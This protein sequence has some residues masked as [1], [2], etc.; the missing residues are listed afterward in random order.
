MRLGYAWR[1]VPQP[2]NVEI[3]RR[4]WYKPGMESTYNAIKEWVSDPVV[5]VILG[6]VVTSTLLRFL[7]RFISSRKK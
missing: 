4:L 1:G 7:R 3:H 2:L 6:F 5:A